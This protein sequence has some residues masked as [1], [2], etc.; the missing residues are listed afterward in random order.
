MPDENL[1]Y[2]TFFRVQIQPFCPLGSKCVN[3]S[4]GPTSGKGK[5]VEFCRP[6]QSISGRKNDLNCVA[7]Q[8]TGDMLYMSKV[9][10]M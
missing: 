1:K 7:S 6:K 3:P 4:V 9:A 10:I 5:D 2:G 8:R